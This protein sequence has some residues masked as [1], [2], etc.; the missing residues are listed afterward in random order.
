MVRKSLAAIVIVML[1]FFIP[2]TADCRADHFFATG[3]RDRPFTVVI[4]PGHGG[5]DGGAKGVY[6][7]EKNVALA[8][9][10]KLGEMI[11]DS[12]PGVKVIFTRTTDI[13]PGNAGNVR[14]GLKNRADI[15]NNAQGDLFI[16]IHCNA[17]Y[18]HIR[19]LVGH[20]TFYERGRHGK[21]IRK[22]EPV[23]RTY[24]YPSLAQGTEVYVWKAE[25][26]EQKKEVLKENAS[27]ILDSSEDPAAGGST[28]PGSPE[29]TIML[30][31]VNRMYF[32][33][34]LN[35]MQ[36]IESEFDRAGRTNRG[37]KQRDVGIWVLQATA[38]PAVLVET[39]FITNREE[40]KYLNSESGQL[41]IAGCI[42]R[43]VKAYK[44]EQSSGRANIAG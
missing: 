2:L 3:G 19:R 30:S 37:M 35:L 34:S 28:M 23:Y 31:Y 26:N 11:R 17:A 15:A 24:S 36:K 44:T 33:Q 1:N 32:D 39:G 38:M 22:R 4:D 5:L 21:R 7:Y 12:M 27:V 41:E 40:E 18:T 6:S 8:V 29:S 14:A 20:R 10:L 16:S 42:F 13:L 43:A 25:K 9:A